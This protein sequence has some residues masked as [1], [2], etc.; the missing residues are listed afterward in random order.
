MTMLETMRRMKLEEQLKPSE[1]N[2]TT[3][4]EEPWQTKMHSAHSITGQTTTNTVC[5]RHLRTKTA[6]QT[7]ETKNCRQPA[8]YSRPE[9]GNK[10]WLKTTTK[11]MV[12]TA[13]A[14]KV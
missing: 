3:Q 10:S 6:N 9:E 7:K 12:Q 5:A 2:H 4:P 11:S 8:K 13:R 14:D 1:C